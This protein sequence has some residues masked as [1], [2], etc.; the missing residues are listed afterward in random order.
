MATAEQL[1]AIA[2]MQSE[3]SPPTGTSGLRNISYV[4]APPNA[5]AEGIDGVRRSR[6]VRHGDLRTTIR[7]VLSGVREGVEGRAVEATLER[8]DAGADIRDVE[9]NALA[10]VDRHGSR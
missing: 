5:E 7:E 2:A 3:V 10:N 1:A 9:G 4:A 6:Q 8:A